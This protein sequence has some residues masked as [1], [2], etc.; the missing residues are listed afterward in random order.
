MDKKNNFKIETDL[1][2]ALIT[3]DIQKKIKITKTSKVNTIHI[4]NNI[5]DKIDSAID[6]NLNNETY[7]KEFLYLTKLGYKGRYSDFKK[8]NITEKGY[9]N[10]RAYKNSIRFLVKKNKQ[11]SDK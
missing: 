6:K 7:I 1:A 10:R 8:H 2:K 9:L 3:K 11:R 4:T 5:N